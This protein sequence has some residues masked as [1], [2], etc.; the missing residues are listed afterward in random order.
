NLSSPASAVFTINAAATKL[1]FSAQPSD[2]ATGA[3][4]NPS[5]QV[6]I[7]DANGNVVTNATNSVTLSIG[8]NP[9]GAT[10]SGA[11]T[12]PPVNGVAAFSNLSLNKA[13]SGYTLTATSNPAL[14]GATSAS[15]NV[16]VSTLAPPVISPNGGNYTGPVIVRLSTTSVG[17]AI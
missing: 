7:E 12:A 3:A 17:A 5:V 4:I 15:F 1:A 16:I 9:G 10:L 13:G 2:A 11:L 14:T 8:A 6:A